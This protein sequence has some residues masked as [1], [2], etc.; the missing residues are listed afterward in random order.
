MSLVINL[1]ATIKVLPLNMDA[2]S[3]SIKINIYSYI[4]RAQATFNAA[5]YY[6]FIKLL[7]QTIVLTVDKIK[8]KL[9]MHFTEQYN[10]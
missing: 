3:T 9:T 4:F 5:I 7:R 10:R 6:Q 8:L 1:T 2:S